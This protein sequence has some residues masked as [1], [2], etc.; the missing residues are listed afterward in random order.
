MGR[1]GTRVIW[2]KLD[3]L[4]PSL[5]K[6]QPNRPPAWH[7]TPAPCPALALFELPGATSGARSDAL[8]GH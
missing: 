7:L 5:Q 2:R 4:N 8:S 3:C 1:W 6:M